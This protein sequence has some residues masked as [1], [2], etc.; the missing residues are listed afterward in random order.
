MV[1]EDKLDKVFIKLSNSPVLYQELIDAVEDK[2]IEAKNQL[3][4]CA[5]RAL[6]QPEEVPQACGL[7]GV[8]QTWEDTLSHLRHIQNKRSG[9]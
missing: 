8:Y 9:L 6:Y 7:R 2:A 4:L 5:V 3:N 1:S